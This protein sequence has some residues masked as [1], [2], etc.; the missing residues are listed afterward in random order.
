MGNKWPNGLEVGDEIE[1]ANHSFEVTGTGPSEAIAEHEN[2][3]E[4]E[5]FRWAMTDA[6]GVE[7]RNNFTQEEFDKLVTK[8]D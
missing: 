7:V 6:V 4:V 5:V 2:G 3:F 8:N 1:I